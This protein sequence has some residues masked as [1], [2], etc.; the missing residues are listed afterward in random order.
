MNRPMLTAGAA[1]IVMQLVTPAH[2]QLAGSRTFTGQITS[3]QSAIVDANGVS[4]A[5]VISIGDDIEVTFAWNLPSAPAGV[6]LAA[7]SGVVLLY[8]LDPSY[9]TLT[10]RVGSLA[11]GG[12]PI[13]VTVGDN[14]TSAAVLSPTDLWGLQFGQIDVCPP[15]FANPLAGS[16][17]FSDST[18]TVFSSSDFIVPASSAPFSSSIFTFTLMHFDPATGTCPPT[19]FGV[20]HASGVEIAAVDDLDG[21]GVEDSLDNCPTVAN[22]DQLDADGNGF[23]DACVSPTSRVSPSASVGF[24]LV[25]GSNSGIGA[26]AVVGAFAKL[27]S[28]AVIQPNASVGDRLELGDRSRIAPLAT[29]G[30]DVVIGDDTTIQ[31]G[32]SI[33]DGAT[34]GDNVS[35][36]SNVDIGFDATLGDRVRIGPRATIGDGAR[37]GSDVVISPGARVAPGAVLPDGT[38]I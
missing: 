13:A 18:G 11:L 32:A 15:S 10:G 23:G 26:N 36:G 19:I 27:G 17:Y 2:A 38:R 3:V 24:G 33:A 21:D 7:L 22:P 29:V 30:T 5:D 28:F 14:A 9:V 8:S 1:A 12:S 4:A 6:P 35:I 20:A 31:P 34:L 25:A 16:L 37:I